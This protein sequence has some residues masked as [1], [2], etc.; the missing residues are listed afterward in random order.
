M[1]GDCPLCREPGGLLV[2][3]APKFRVIRAQEPDFPALYRVVWQAHVAE[4]SD[5][6]ADD[7]ALCMEAVAVVER[8]MRDNLRPD[9][10]NLAALGNM[11]PH[12]HWHVIARYR[13]DSRWPAPSWAPVQ[14]DVPVAT[15]SPISEGLAALDARLVADFS[16]LAL[17]RV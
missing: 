17:F 13:W 3:Q 15:W 5:L 14:R 11:V 2:F 4:W 10:I 9:K 7:R 8:A 6:S 16:A 12:L 1:V